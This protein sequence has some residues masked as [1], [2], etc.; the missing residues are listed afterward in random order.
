MTDT[1]LALA[2]TPEIND[3]NRPYWDEL[4]RGALTFQRC[5]ACRWAWLPAREEC[6]NCLA[7]DWSRECAAGGA[8]LVSW[9]VYHHAYHP[10]F[11]ARLPYTVAVVQL[12][13]GPRLI[14]NV[15]GDAAALKIDQRLALRIEQESGMAVPRFVAAKF[16]S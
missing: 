11:V 7:D 2:P 16:R 14:S 12:D 15:A 6:P 5:R 4:A 9:V 3:L 8:S 1:A 10:A 13:E